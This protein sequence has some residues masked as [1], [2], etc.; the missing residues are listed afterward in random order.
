MLNDFT[1]GGQIFL[2]KLR[3]FFQVLHRSFM[4]SML[5]SLAIVGFISYRPVQTL[6]LRAA[7]TYQKALL[8]D[9]FDDAIS[10]IRTSINP[11]NKDHFTTIDAYDKRGLYARD[12]D[13]RKIINSFCFRASYMEVIDFLKMRLA[14]IIGVMCGIFIII[15]F[16]WSR[17]GREI[18]SE[19][20]KEGSGIVLTAKQVRV[21]L[22]QLKLCSELKI[23]DMP[24][25][26]DM[27]TRHFL[28]T[29]STGSGKTNLIHNLLLQIEKKKQPVIIIDQT[30][31]MIAKYYDEE[32]G[33]IIFNPFD[34]RGKSWDFWADCGS[35]ED[36]ERF[37]KILI[38][39]NRKQSGSRSDP[40]WE[41][42]AEAVFNSCIEFL[43]PRNA[44]IKD[45][46]NMVCYTDI[47]YLK[48]ILA[49][50]E[51]ARYLGD[52]SK[53]TASSICS[54][55]A[56][57]AKPLSYLTEITDN[58]AF[59]MK[60]Y[61]TSIK[62]GSNAF[63]FLA[64]KPSARSL[65]L[66]L[67]ACLTELALAELM[68]I[69]IDKNR[70]VWTIIDELPTLGLLPSLS[71]LM[72]E[73]R[74]YGAC[75]IACMQSLNQLFDKYGQYAGSSIFGQ[76]GTSFFFRNTEPAIAKMISSMCGSETI[77]RQQKNTSFGAN[78]FRD[79]VSYSEHQ[80][81]NQIVE[82]D[83]LAS[84][85]T[86]ECYTLFAEPSVRLARLRIPEIDV[87]DKHMGFMKKKEIENDVTMVKDISGTF[88]EQQ[89]RDSSE[90]VEPRNSSTNFE[91]KSSLAQTKRRKKIKQ[92][93]PKLNTKTIDNGHSNKISDGFIP[94]F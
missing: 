23:G 61:F 51:A 90:N 52:D 87:K 36:L 15:Y 18:K 89:Q 53:Q 9:S 28:I 50:S 26:K 81:K 2:H 55:L 10:N 48:T 66:P 13:P 25:V 14:L 57:N 24:L 30:G 44:S 79:G 33:D 41:S 34:A 7:M 77:T 20:K 78:E 42:A 11:K 32:R 3:M 94:E 86:G 29:G 68:E 8:A 60:K 1:G 43:R 73:G 12:I 17:F 70:R 47:A 76:F 58:G 22:Q 72:A 45:V 67:I 35:R 93:S 65:T 37:S 54:V 6:D 83:D 84:L 88:L 71:P 69:G 49:N 5:V 19:K 59:S 74:K 21:K 85:A 80:Q 62:N 16:L 91:V 56:A 64:T 82:I 27:E 40:F 92:P 4:T 63:L 46:V 31:E 38:S 75:V 39:F